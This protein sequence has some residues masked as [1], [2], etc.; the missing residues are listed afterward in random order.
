MKHT[1]SF[2]TKFLHVFMCGTFWMLGSEVA[3]A[4]EINWQKYMQSSK[5]VS[6]I[7]AA[8][9]WVD[10]CSKKVVIKESISEGE[11]RKVR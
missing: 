3:A 10:S 11:V 8:V 7:A 4:A 6:A 9:S 1:K 5:N 2:T